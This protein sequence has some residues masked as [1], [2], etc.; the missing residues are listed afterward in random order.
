MVI[1]PERVT[2]R[3]VSNQPAR[4]ILPYY[5]PSVQGC[6][7]W[8]RGTDGHGYGATGWFDGQRQRCAK[9]HRILFEGLVGPIPEGLDLDHLCRNR[10]CVNPAHLEPVTRKENVRRGQGHGSETHCPKGHEYTPENLYWAKSGARICRPCR[11]E[12]S[13]QYYW[14]KRR[15]GNIKRSTHLD[16]REDQPKWD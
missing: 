6:W 1:V 2:R 14:R 9:A 4:G 13:R 11:I 10:A 12:W 8:V 5:V 3:L 15:E 7:V 16:G